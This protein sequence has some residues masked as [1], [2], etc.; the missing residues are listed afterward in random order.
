MA[1]LIEALNEERKPRL[2]SIVERTLLLLREPYPCAVRV[3]AHDNLNQ[4]CRI[5][6]KPGQPPVMART[7]YARVTMTRVRTS[8]CQGSHRSH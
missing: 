7:V 3:G 5:S 2:R 8:P 6:K 1:P 4:E